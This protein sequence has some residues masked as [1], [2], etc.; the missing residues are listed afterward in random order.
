MIWEVGHH[1]KWNGIDSLAHNAHGCKTSTGRASYKSE[2]HCNA[3][4]SDWSVDPDFRQRL[5]PHWPLAF[6]Q[7]DAKRA[8]DEKCSSHG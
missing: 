8:F 4:E 7:K 1:V 6:G 5:S 2:T 3:W